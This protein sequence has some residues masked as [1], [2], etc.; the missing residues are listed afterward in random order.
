MLTAGQWWLYGSIIFLAAMVVHLTALPGSFFWDDYDW[1]VNNP[2]VRDPAGLFRLWFD[3]SQYDY[4]PMHYTT[5]WFEWRLWGEW[6]PPYR[7]LNQLMH[8]TDCVLLW[9]ILR[10]MRVPGAWL[11]AMIFAVHPLNV[12]SVVWI[13]QRK[14][15]QS[16][17]FVFGSL[18]CYFR[19]YDTPSRRWYTAAVVLFALGLLTKTSVVMWPLAMLV[20]VWWRQRKLLARDLLACGPFLVLS[21][22]LGVMGT[23]M[24]GEQLGIEL[25]RD[26]G[27]LS[28]LAI[29]GDVVWF[30]VF[31]ALWPFGLS[32]VY[33]RWELGHT[34]PLAFVPLIA[35]IALFAVCWVYRK[36]WGAAPLA[37][38]AYYLI[39]LFPVLGFV[40]IMF[41]RYSLVADHWQYLALPGLLAPIVGAAS[42]QWRRFPRLRY[43]GLTIST[44]VVFALAY[45]S[46]VQSAIWSGADNE[47]IWR[48]VLTKN[49]H[50]ELP[51]L[52]LG[53]VLAQRGEFAEAVQ[54]ICE[55]TK[56]SVPPASWGPPRIDQQRLANAT[57]HRYEQI[58]LAT[59][60]DSIRI[61]YTIGTAMYVLGQDDVAFRY[62]DSCVK[63]APRFAAAHYNLSLVL[64]QLGYP[65]EAGAYRR[66]ASYLAEQ[67]MEP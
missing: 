44:A 27:F 38:G 13:S 48:D 62:L 65:D 23:L 57:G 39:N 15:V 3:L 2:R 6:A 43:V 59:A 4:W 9:A 17:A 25:A 53:Y 50:G 46:L 21:L 31:K 18:L 67:A 61:A 26:D 11:C 42:Q 14:T 29:A 7:V 8:A 33:P 22:A 20:C 51:H 19:Y 1:V 55:S 52:R 16:T 49:P 36:S 63:Q 64:D 35:L 47:P 45:G 58:G 32:V 66:N 24:R 60:S 28:R 41:M 12:E 37:S 34:E 30:Y 54:Q 56:H 40:G 5:H 10:W